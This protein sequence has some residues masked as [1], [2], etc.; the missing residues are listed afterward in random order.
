[1]ADPIAELRLGPTA[2]TE[3]IR[4]ALQRLVDKV[5]ELVRAHNESLED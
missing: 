5:N 4:L 1:M 3:D 2:T